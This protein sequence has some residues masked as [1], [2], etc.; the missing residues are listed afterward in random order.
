MIMEVSSPPEYASTTF[1][2]SCLDFTA[3]V[4]SSLN[5]YAG[6]MYE[7]AAFVKGFL[8]YF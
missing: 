8:Q 2:I 4:V 6:I 5:I 3:M 7:T 1:L